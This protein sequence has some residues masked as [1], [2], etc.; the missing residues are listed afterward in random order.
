[1]TAKEQ[2]LPEGL[3]ADIDAMRDVYLSPSQRGAYERILARA[4]TYKSALASDTGER[5]GV[6]AWLHE[7]AADDGEPDQALSFSRNSFPLE[8]VAGYRTVSVR[9]LVCGDTLRAQPQ[10]VEGG[11][12]AE[13]PSDEVWPPD[14]AIWLAPVATDAPANPKLMQY[15]WG[16]SSLSSGQMAEAYQCIVSAAQECGQVYRLPVAAP[17]Q[18]DGVSK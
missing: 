2:G 13:P 5:G 15:A 6:V 9:P 10:P 4:A 3:E 16:R 7:V 12:S 1:M 17:A 8:G 11:E 14:G 18:P